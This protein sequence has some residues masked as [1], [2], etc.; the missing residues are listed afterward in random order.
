MS[1]IGLFIFYSCNADLIRNARKYRF[2]YFTL[3]LPILS[4]YSVITVIGG[5]SN[6][7][8]SLTLYDKENKMAKKAAVAEK[9]VK[10]VKAPKEEKPKKP[11]GSVSGNMLETLKA[12]KNGK[13]VSHDIIAGVT[14]RAKGNK[15][16]ELEELGYVKKGEEEG[17]RGYVY[18]ITKAGQVALAKS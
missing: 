14:G 4:T 17:V 16:R 12:M 18:Q 13:A 11:E 6:F 5:F 7:T 9:P 10:A 15:L 1:V 3:A 2:I 8:E